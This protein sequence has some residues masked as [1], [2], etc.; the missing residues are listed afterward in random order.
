M[1]PSVSVFIHFTYCIYFAS[2][3]VDQSFTPSTNVLW[4]N[5]SSYGQTTCCVSIHLL[6]GHFGGFPFW[7]QR[8][9]LPWTVMFKFLS[10]DLFSILLGIRPGVEL[11]GHMGILWLTYWGT[12]KL[13]STALL[14]K[15]SCKFMSL[16]P[17]FWCGW[18][19]DWFDQSSMEVMPCDL[20][21][22]HETTCS[23]CYVLGSSCSWSPEVH[24]I[25]KT[26]L[27]PGS[28]E[29]SWTLCAVPAR[30]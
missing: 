24:I 10:E 9:V 25:S 2:C 23:L 3:N 30:I 17:S 5:I 6:M 28:W 21:L 8:I 11:L 7:L 1:W 14:L 19:G 27:D 13:V 22:D 18:A 20:I 29:P 15:H 4:L 12:S 26:A 16:S